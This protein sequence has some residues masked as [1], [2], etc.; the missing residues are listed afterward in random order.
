MPGTLPDAARDIMAILSDIPGIKNCTL[1]GS[2]ASGKYD[3]LSD[4]D[5][6]LTIADGDRG[7]FA[8]ALPGLLAERLPVFYAD[9][10][11]SL[12]P[13]KYV[14]SVAIDETNPFRMVDLCVSGGYDTS[15][16][17]KQ[18]LSAQNDRFTHVMKLWTANLKHHA[19]GADCRG[20]ITKMARRLETDDTGSNG[21]IL[22]DA[23]IWLENNAPD[24]L[25]AYVASCRK[26][27][28]MLI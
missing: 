16:V 2:L 15:C 11:P 20:D 21:E 12:A 24:R 3:D 10:A 23:L 8:L 7:E 18:Q 17:T 14:L 9:Y 26:A 4:I 6:E 19:R 25:K 28:E 1:Y 5:I 27:Y 22:A 13:E